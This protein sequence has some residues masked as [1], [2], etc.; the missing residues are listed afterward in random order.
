MPG[1]VLYRWP[2]S[3]GIA[4][5][6]GG[7]GCAVGSGALYSVR[8]VEAIAGEQPWNGVQGLGPRLWG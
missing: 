6:G 8:W 3:L 4:A 1:T 5:E 2:V 7:E